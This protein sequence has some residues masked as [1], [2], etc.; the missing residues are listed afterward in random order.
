MIAPYLMSTSSRIF[1]EFI[2][3]YTICVQSG[4]DNLSMD[5]DNYTRSL[6][7][8]VIDLICFVSTLCCKSSFMMM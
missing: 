2:F 3:L 8:C 6:Y 5:R 1:V 7:V 4:V